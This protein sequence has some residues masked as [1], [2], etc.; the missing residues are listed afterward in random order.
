[1]V[2]PKLVLALTVRFVEDGSQVVLE[3]ESESTGHLEFF[4]SDD[5][6]ENAEVWDAKGRA[7]IG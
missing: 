7:G 4:D 1:M 3:N 5:P 2:V 6:E